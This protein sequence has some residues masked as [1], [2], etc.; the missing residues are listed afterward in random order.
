MPW[1][2]FLLTA[3]ASKRLSCQITRAK[4]ST[5]SSFSAASCSIA[6]Q[7]SS[8]V[9]GCGAADRADGGVRLGVEGLAAAGFIGTGFGAAALGAA[10]AGGFA[11]A[12]LD[13]AGLSFAAGAVCGC[14]S[15]RPIHSAA[16]I[17][18]EVLTAAMPVNART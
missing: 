6:R 16:A 13:V 3:R 2:P 10:V 8:A 11:V 17:K 4:N 1:A 14:A 12:G 15:A 5:G 7:I 18:T 9:G